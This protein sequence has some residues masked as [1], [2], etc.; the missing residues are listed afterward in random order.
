M[1]DW[2]SIVFIT[3]GAINF[4][5]WRRRVAIA[6]NSQFIDRLRDDHPAL[7]AIT[8]TALSKTLRNA[9]A[10]YWD[11]KNRVLKERGKK[12]R[13]RRQKPPSPAIGKDRQFGGAIEIA[14]TAIGKARCGFNVAPSPRYGH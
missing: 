11:E 6:Y 8:K 3:G 2:N 5:Q 9:G 7:K 10:R 12:A 4:G 1:V 14:I 13:C